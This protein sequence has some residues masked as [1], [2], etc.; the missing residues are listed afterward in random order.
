[1]SEHMSEVFGF[2]LF[3]A[4]CFLLAWITKPRKKFIRGHICVSDFPVKPNP[5]I[6]GRKNGSL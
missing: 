4:A 2:H 5:N 3:F 6:K 1:M